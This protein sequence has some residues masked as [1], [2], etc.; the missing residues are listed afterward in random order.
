MSTLT[1][2][3]TIEL[4]CHRCDGEGYVCDCTDDLR[5]GDVGFHG[6]CGACPDCSDEMTVSRG[7]ATF[8][9]CVVDPDYEVRRNYAGVRGTVPVKPAWLI[10]LTEPC[11][12][13]RWVTLPGVVPTAGCPDCFDSRPAIEVIVNIDHGDGNGHQ[14]HRHGTVEH[15]LPVYDTYHPEPPEKTGE[16]FAWIAPDGRCMIGMIRGLNYLD[17]DVT[18]GQYVA[19]IRMEEP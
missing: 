11:Q 7:A 10:E 9:V 8:D 13:P 4:P 1:A 18:P 16:P 12:H 14:E 3:T 5:F 17:I 19:L 6:S 15:V 2:Q